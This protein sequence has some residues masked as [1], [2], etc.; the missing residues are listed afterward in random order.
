MKSPNFK[1][2]FQ[3][4]RFK[5]GGF[6]TLIAVGFVAAVVILNVIASV[7]VDRYPL[8]I[9]MT[10]EGIF[11]LSDQTV[12]YI[13]EL[14]QDVDIIVLSNKED[15]LNSGD[16]FAQAITVLDN[17]QK[18]SDHIKIQYLDILKDP[19]IV[20]QYPELQLTSGDI[21]IKTDKRSK[22]LATSDLFNTEMDYNYYQEVITSSKAEQVVSSSIEYVTADQTILVS[23]ITGHDEIEST[24]LA[25]ILSL[26]NYDT[27]SQRILSED[28]N[29]DAQFIVVNSPKRDYTPEEIKRLDTF[30]DNGGNYGKTLLYFAGDDQPALPNLEAFLQEWGIAVGEGTVYETDTNLLASATNPFYAFVNFQ[31]DDYT[32]RL[33][34]RDLNVLM[35][36][37]RPLSTI[38]EAKGNISTE[39]LLSYSDASYLYP[40]DPE[41]GYAPS[42]NDEKGP[43][44]ALIR[45]EK[46][47]Y[48]GTTPLT[49]RVFVFAS[50]M[51]VDEDF[52][53][54]TVVG[55]GE[56]AVSLLNTVSEK[57]SGLNI[58]SKTVGAS[59]ISVTAAQGITLGLVFM[60][61]LPLA[62]LVF[63]IVVWMKRR[64]K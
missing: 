53:S 36:Y 16:Y 18:Y 55:N 20:S 40:A 2:L 29:P 31:G 26:N 51:A 49:S 11:G 12:N 27:V 64:N 30:L 45:G 9:D 50:S 8:T 15:Y 3:S 10:K 61:L 17:Y 44:G 23:L 24:G 57:K 47:R 43:F 52:T 46:T 62:V 13:K 48:D 14:D 5:Y 56:Y 7:L 54:I 34:G 37:G 6:A 32:E 60:I 33:S 1:R 58:V 59:Q 25:S 28:I 41:E 22:K 4:R 38:F 21:L 19:A 39:T 35:P 63:G 42:T